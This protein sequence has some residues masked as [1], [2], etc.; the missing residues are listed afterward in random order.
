MIFSSLL[1]DIAWPTND[2]D[3]KIAATC[4]KF[5]SL[6]RRGEFEFVAS[7]FAREDGGERRC[8]LIVRHRIRNERFIFWSTKTFV[9]VF[10]TDHANSYIDV[11]EQAMRWL[12]QF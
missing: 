11:C 5:Y 9:R 4:I 1:N 3:E 8:N 10:G 2:Y 6:V 12:R 7:S